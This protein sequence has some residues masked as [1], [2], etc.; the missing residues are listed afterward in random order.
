MMKQVYTIEDCLELLAGLQQGPTIKIES[1]DMTIIH[2]IARQVFRG[3]ALTDRQYEVMKEKMQTYKQQFASFEYDIESAIKVLRQPLRQ[4]DRSKYITIVDSTEVFENSVYE[5]YKA[6]WKWIKIRFPFSKKLIAALDNIAYCDRMNHVHKKNSHIHYFP[7]KEKTV[8]AVLEKF[9]DKNF[10]ICSELLEYNNKIKHIRKNLDDYFPYVDE[11]NIYNL[12]PKSKEV[13]LNELGMPTKENLFLFQ[14]RS[15]KYGLHTVKGINKTDSLVS[16][17]I[18]RSRHNIL[19]KPSKYKL[20]E[21]ISTIAELKR[22]PLLI[23]INGSLEEINFLYTEISKIIPS[24][25]HSVLFRLDNAGPDELFN[26]Y[27][28]QNNMNVSLDN[29]PNVVYI[30]KN[31]KFPKPLIQKKWQPSCMLVLESKYSGR[32]RSELTLNACD[33]VIAYDNENSLLNRAQFEDIN[34]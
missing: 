23:E 13:L 3:T 27:I 7:V 5:S 28:K 25:T 4:I 14:D 22:L 21:V 18:F 15:T 19:I 16:K 29:S 33:L 2:S 34:G 9:G 20:S 30:S 12:L 24:A 31:S 11:S 17:V 8:E 6:D 26:Q 1:S 32:S 10:E